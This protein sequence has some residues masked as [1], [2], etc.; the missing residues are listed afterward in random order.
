MKKCLLVLLI[1]SLCIFL[2]GFGMRFANNT[3]VSD[4]G[5][6]LNFAGALLIAIIAMFIVIDAQKRKKSEKKS[7]LA[8]NDNNNENLKK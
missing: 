2:V 1:V 6:W 5:L 8:V 4:I 3:M 7:S